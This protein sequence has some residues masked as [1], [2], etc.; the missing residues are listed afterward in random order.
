MGTPLCATGSEEETDWDRSHVIICSPAGAGCSGRLD[1]QLTWHSEDQLHPD[2]GAELFLD[3]L[4]V[5]FV[6][7]SITPLVRRFCFG[8]SPH[9]YS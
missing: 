6:S 5:A 3:P 2:V 7:L 8:K 1:L 4:Q 9:M